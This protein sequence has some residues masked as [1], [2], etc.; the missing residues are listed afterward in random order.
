VNFDNAT[1][2]LSFSQPHVYVGAVTYGQAAI[3]L[4]T[5]QSFI[6]EFEATLAT[7]RIAIDDFARQMSAFY[8]QQ[9]QQVMTAPY[10][11][12]DMV[13]VVAGFNEKEAYGRVYLFGIP[14]QPTPVEHSANE[15]GLTWGG[16]R[17]IVD[18]IIQGY[19]VQLLP[20]AQGALNLQPAQTQQL[21]QALAPLQMAL[22]LQ[23]MPLQDCV[24][25]AIFF[26]RT[27]I[28]AQSLT[29]G[30]RGCGGPIDVAI[31]TSR[32]NLQFVQRKTIY[33]EAG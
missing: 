21:A 1:K 30:L 26:I 25:L 28:A 13:F 4:R 32:D 11:G 20:I 17:E 5:A 12:P 15:F 9:W 7:G 6:P 8:L 14:G 10:Q 23:A 16:Q 31:I 29:V 3:G 27:T 2:V 24:D 19:D 18:R 33:G 22:P